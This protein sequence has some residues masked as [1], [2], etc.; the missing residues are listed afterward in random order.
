MYLGG[1]DRD[2][3]GNRLV[4]TGAKVLLFLWGIR[5]KQHNRQLIDKKKSYVYVANHRSDL[6]GIITYAIMP[7][8]F[9][10]IGK[11]QILSWP[12]F[13]FLVGHLHITVDRSSPESRKQ[14][15]VKMNETIKNGASMQVFPEGWCNFSDEFVLPLKKG[16]FRIAT[17]TQTPLLVFTMT[18]NGELWPKTTLKMRPG[19]THVY[20]EEIIDVDGLTEHDEKT[21]K[22]KV[23]QIWTKRLQSTY[24]D[25]YQNKD[26][27]VPFEVWK[28]KQLS[29]KS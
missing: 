16:A 25:G 7:G 15:M 9:K 20:W 27:K 5:V 17:E 3:I 1:S 29:N 24:P 14:S 21:L 26:Q 13:G 2:R 18:G 12:F 11:T 19:V 28:A 8:D 6:D 23:K 10:F 4:Y 22:A